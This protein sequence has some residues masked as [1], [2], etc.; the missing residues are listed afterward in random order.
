MGLA[1]PTYVCSNCQNPSVSKIDDSNMIKCYE[2]KFTWCHTCGLSGKNI[3]HT[4]PF[5]LLICGGMN[6]SP[7]LTI[8]GVLWRFI[9]YTLMLP[10]AIY[11]IMGTVWNQ[12]LLQFPDLLAKILEKIFFC[13]LV[14][15][16]GCIDTITDVIYL[17]VMMVL[18]FAQALYIAGSL[19]AAFI[20]AI[21]ITALLIA[22]ALLFHVTAFLFS[23]NQ[24]RKEISK[25]VE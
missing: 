21:P 23:L 17:L 10:F 5:A 14:T 19:G 24:W 4:I 9:K 8:F 11:F 13:S 15:G 1:Q 22:P 25:Y 18:C 2:C 20:V 16:N 12:F 3:M 7:S 6:L